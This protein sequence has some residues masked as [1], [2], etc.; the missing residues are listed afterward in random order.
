MQITSH[1]FLTVEPD[2]GA[3]PAFGDLPPVPTE[4]ADED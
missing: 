1:L 4:V 3:P 2:L